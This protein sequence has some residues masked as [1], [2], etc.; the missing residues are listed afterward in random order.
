M[1]VFFNC[2]LGLH[3]FANNVHLTSRLTGACAYHRKHQLYLRWRI[4]EH[5]LIPKVRQRKFIDSYFHNT[6][7]NISI[8][9]SNKERIYAKYSY[10]P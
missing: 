8:Y 9:T 10:E 7:D 5:V 2:Q 1:F 6:T 4:N 3:N